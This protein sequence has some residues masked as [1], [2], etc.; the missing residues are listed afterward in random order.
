MRR[1][2]EVSDK[3]WEFLRP[4]LERPAAKTGRKPVHPRDMLNGILWVLRTGAPWR[5]VPDCYGPW[6]TVYHYFCLW[7][8][9]GALSQIVISLQTRMDRKGQIDWDLF[10]IDGAIVRAAH[11]A[12]GASK[13]VSPGM[14]RSRPIMPWGAAAAGSAPSSTW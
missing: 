14:R 11:A 13:K 3:Q 1:R 5:D 2:H 8:D 7:R 4:F 9:N 12:A 10:C 6:Q